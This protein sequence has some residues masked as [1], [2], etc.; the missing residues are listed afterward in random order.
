MK[1]IIISPPYFFAGPTYRKRRRNGV[2]AAL[3]SPNYATTSTQATSSTNTSP[4]ISRWT[5]GASTSAK[6]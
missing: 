6:N 5:S 3:W 4:K 1:L 2:R